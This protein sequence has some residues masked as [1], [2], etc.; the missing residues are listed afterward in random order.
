MSKG[1]QQNLFDV[2]KELEAI[3][4]IVEILKPISAEG[5]DRVLAFLDHGIRQ[6]VDSERVFGET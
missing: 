1:K 2:D 4:Q 3:R 6:L 5:R